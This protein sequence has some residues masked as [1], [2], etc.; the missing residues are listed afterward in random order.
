MVNGQA[1]EVS[2][3]SPNDH[4]RLAQPLTRSVSGAATIAHASSAVRRRPSRA[5]RLETADLDGRLRC[6]TK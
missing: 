4:R 6:V 3:T 5:C 1:V 2:G